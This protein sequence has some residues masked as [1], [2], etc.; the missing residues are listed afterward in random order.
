MTALVSRRDLAEPG[1]YRYPRAGQA[2]AADVVAAASRAASGADTSAL[3]AEHSAWW[4]QFWNQSSIDLG[5]RY[6]I[7]EGWW[8]GMQ[9]ILG[10]ASRAG[11]V[12]PS[13]FGPWVISD[14]P[15]WV[16]DITMDCE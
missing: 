8:Y 16:D 1:Q 2:A 6:Q 12:V 9:Y 4:R 15:S 5:P 14:P 10:S 3:R 13:L 7:L 11:E